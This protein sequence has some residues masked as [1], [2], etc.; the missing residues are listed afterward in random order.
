[1][2]SVEASLT[3]QKDT[4]GPVLVIGAGPAGLATSHELARNGVPHLVV[5]RGRHVGQTWADLYDSLV[6][7]TARGLSTL[8]GLA[9]PRETPIFPSRR[10]FW[11]Y[12]SRY[13]E[14]FK[15][16]VQ[17]STDIVALGRD[18]GG[19][20]AR[21]ASGETLSARAVVVATGI[22]ANPFV[23]EIP[24]QDRFG[25]RV[26]H[27]VHYHRPDDLADRRVL[28]VGAGNSA[29]EIA[30]ELARAGAKVALAVRTGGAVLPRDIAGIPMH[31]LAVGLSFLPKASQ[32]AA[33]TLAN[34]IQMVARGPGVLPPPA[35]TRCPKIPLIG[36]HLVDAIREGTIQIRGRLKEFTPDG[37]RFGDDASEPFDAVILATGYR[38]AVGMLHGSIRLDDCGFGLRRDRVVSVDQPDL[39]FVG[40]NY[41]IRG[42]LFNIGRDAKRAVKRIIATTRDTS[43]RAT[44]IS[45]PASER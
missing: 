44:E 38:A 14:T 43:R 24:Y 33:M 7:H 42:G 3:S 34:R 27:S 45:R 16:P 35:P 26:F 23:P 28:V 18:N 22:V 19:W 8:P 20:L 15:L 29:G 40:H 31:Y 30:V 25:G 10:E 13:A 21:T 41:D 2:G 37:V 5:E 9:F 11:Q 1:L 36:F 17:T 6:L 39:Y 12:L 4:R 32:R